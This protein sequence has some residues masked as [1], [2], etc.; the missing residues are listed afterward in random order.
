LIL[1]LAT[2]VVPSKNV[3]SGDERMPQLKC[4]D[5]EAAIDVP[6]DAVDGEIVTCPDC[7]LDLEVHITPQGPSLKPLLVTKEDWGE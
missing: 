4:V 6:E 7:G 1:D 3:L 5:C 2:S